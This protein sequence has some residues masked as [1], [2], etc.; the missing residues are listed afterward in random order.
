MTIRKYDAMDEKGIISLKP[1]IG[2]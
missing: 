2:S 1:M